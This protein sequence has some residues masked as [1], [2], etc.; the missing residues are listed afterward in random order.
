MAQQIC[1]RGQG[2][3]ARGRRPGAGREQLLHSES[4]ERGFRGGRGGRARPPGELTGLNA[5]PGASRA[6]QGEEEPRAGPPPWGFATPGTEPA[7]RG[8][9]LPG[10]GAAGPAGLAG[11]GGAGVGRWGCVWGARV[12]GA[13]A[14]GRE[15]QPREAQ[16]PRTHGP[17]V[18]VMGRAPR[19][20]STRT[21]P[22]PGPPADHTLASPEPADGCS[23]HAGFPRGNLRGHGPGSPRGRFAKNGACK[24]LRP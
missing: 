3:V 9:L 7:C 19:G 18:E 4:T 22:G 23:D 17:R 14:A 12:A 13:L 1:H 20:D 6:P 24:Q 15:R 21:L 11:V 2:R 16:V 10:D 8:A 5:G